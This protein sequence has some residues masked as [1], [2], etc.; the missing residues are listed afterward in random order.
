MSAPDWRRELRH[1][2]KGAERGEREAR[3]LCPRE[4]RAGR[5]GEQTCRASLVLKSV[6]DLCLKSAERVRV[7]VKLVKNPRESSSW[8]CQ[9]K[10]NESSF[11]WRLRLELV[12]RFSWSS[13]L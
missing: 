11:G 1:A 2:Q 4:K 13:E 8:L 3:G 6:K 9:D 5:G 7:R 12:G 10:L